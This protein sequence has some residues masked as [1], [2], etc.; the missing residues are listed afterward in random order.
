MRPLSQT[1]PLAAMERLFEEGTIL[2]DPPVDGR[3]IHLHPTFFHE[4]LD[5]ACAQRIRHIPPHPHENDLFGEMGTLKTDRHRRSPSCITVGHRG[6]SY[7][8]SPPMKICDKT[9][10]HH[11]GGRRRWHPGHIAR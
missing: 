7:G 1:L 2:D 3:M 11:H 8:K 9:R 10:K 6:R 4:F 5:M